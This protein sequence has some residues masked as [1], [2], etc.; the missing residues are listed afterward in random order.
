MCARYYLVHKY[1]TAEGKVSLD[2]EEEDKRGERFNGRLKEKVGRKATLNDEQGRKY[3]E[4]VARY[5][6]GI[7]GLKV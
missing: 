6:V 5:C 7:Q 1:G 4:E 3:W 2:E